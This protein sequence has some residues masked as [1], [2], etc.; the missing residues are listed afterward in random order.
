MI[1]KRITGALA[2]EVRQAAKWRGKLRCF[3][4]FEGHCDRQIAVW[5]LVAGRVARAAEQAALLLVRTAITK[6]QF[7]CRL[8][9]E[10]QEQRSR[11]PCIGQ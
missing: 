9:E 8:L 5:L 2:M 4:A 7:G 1:A 6:S 3:Y 11:L 10:W